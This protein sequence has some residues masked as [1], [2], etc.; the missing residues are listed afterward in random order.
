MIRITSGRI[1]KVEKKISLKPSIFRGGF[2][3]DSRGY[4][5]KQ[6]QLDSKI[7][8]GTTNSFN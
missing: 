7:S 8:L 3:G 2:T 6:Q 1:K 4:S 5:K